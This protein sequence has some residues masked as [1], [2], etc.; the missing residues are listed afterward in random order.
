MRAI[1]AIIIILMVFVAGLFVGL[2]A[3]QRSNIGGQV[4]TT[5]LAKTTETLTTRM[6]VT[7]TFTTTQTAGANTVTTTITRLYT[8]T[9]VS[10]DAGTGVIQAVCFSRVEQCDSLLINLI[11]Q[12]RKSVYVAIYSF[13]RDSL[14]RALIDAKK[15]GVEVKVVIEEENAYG[16]GSDYQM[17]KD[18]G[19]DIRLDGNP[20]LMHHK[21]MIVDGE[22]VV[23]GSYNWSTAAEDRNDE[24]FV[25]IRDKEVVDR[26]TQ[27]FNR[28]LSIA[29]P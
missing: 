21:F 2:T 5:V 29:R 28:L 9:V 3:S 22:L 26:F 10:S 16:Q 14:A 27:E 23:T 6:V 13:T 11:S 24:N 12:A 15:R 25:V 20:A 8:T 17:L 19:I 18:A 7:T 4:G 1:N